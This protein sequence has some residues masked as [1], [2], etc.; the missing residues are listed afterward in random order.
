MI[1]INQKIY[2]LEITSQSLEAFHQEKIK[3][4]KLSDYK[5]QWLILL[6][7]PADFTF[8]CSKELDEAAY[9]YQEFKKD[10]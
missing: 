5:S 7:Y 10:A 9:Y 1:K 3:K 4:L 6:F 2:D 8:V